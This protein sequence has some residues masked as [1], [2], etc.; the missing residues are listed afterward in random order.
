[1]RSGD[2][3]GLQNRWAAGFPVAGGFDPHSLPPTYPNFCT[4]PRA[5]CRVEMSVEIWLTEPNFEAFPRNTR[6]YDDFPISEAK[7]QMQA[8][9]GFIVNRCDPACCGLETQADCSDLRLHSER[10]SG[11]GGRAVRASRGAAVRKGSYFMSINNSSND[12]PRP[13][14][15][16]KK[17]YEKPGFRYEQVFV[18]SALGCGKITTTQ[19]GCGLSTKS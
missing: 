10:P 15:I 13:A 18:T 3:P 2:R 6:V 1:M 14:A 5:A 16:E 4:R 7:V 11:A 9:G 19:A 17:P 12:E 8:G